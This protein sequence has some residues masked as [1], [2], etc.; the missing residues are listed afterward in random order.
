MKCINKIRERGVRQQA[1]EQFDQLDKIIDIGRQN[2]SLLSR[3]VAVAEFYAKQ[4]ELMSL[5]DQFAGFALTGMV[6][7]A[8]NTAASDKDLAAF[9]YKQ[10]DSMMKE[11]ENP[12]K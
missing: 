6:T 2:I 4:R 3:N 8:Y 11:R 9:S 10:A 7:A 1:L 12:M 5:R